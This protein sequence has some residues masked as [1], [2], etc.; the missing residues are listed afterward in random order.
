MYDAE[1][2]IHPEE[3]TKTLNLWKCSEYGKMISGDYIQYKL[4]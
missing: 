4:D 2:I 1:S 3:R